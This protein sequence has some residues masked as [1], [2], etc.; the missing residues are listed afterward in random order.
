MGAVLTVLFRSS[1]S[2][3]N[4]NLLTSTFLV[5][6]IV[7]LSQAENTTTTY[8]CP[9]VFQRHAGNDIATFQNIVS[10]QEFGALCKAHYS[11]TM[12]TWVH[13]YSDVIPNWCYL[14]DGTP[15]FESKCQTYA[16]T[17]SCY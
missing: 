8:D 6:L 17:A 5:Y 3:E 13:P 14:H 2:S 12:W 16:G 11:C 9:M 15:S 10:W 1:S 4:M 7:S